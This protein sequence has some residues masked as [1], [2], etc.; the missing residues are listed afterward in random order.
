MI[1]DIEIHGGTE[2]N[3]VLR[4][5]IS[6]PD[7]PLRGSYLWKGFYYAAGWSHFLFTFQM[8]NRTSIEYQD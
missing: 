5:Y 7:C 8:Q 3:L 6:G 4:I 1:L 2:E